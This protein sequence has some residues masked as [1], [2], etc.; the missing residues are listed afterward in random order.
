MPGVI[1]SCEQGEYYTPLK[2]MNQRTQ[3]IFS[4]SNPSTLLPLS[5]YTLTGNIHLSKL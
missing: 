4:M 5:P 1:A 3:G 2:K